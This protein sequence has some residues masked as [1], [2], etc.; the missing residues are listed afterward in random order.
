VYPSFDL[1]LN[2]E[3]TPNTYEVWPGEMPIGQ[4]LHFLFF[5]RNATGSGTNGFH[6]ILN[7]NNQQNWYGSFYT[8]N[9]LEDITGSGAGSG[10]PPF[11]AGQ[12][13]TWDI[14]FSGSATVDLIY[15]PC[16]IADVCA[17]GLGTQLVQ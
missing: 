16:G 8:P 14:K 3:C 12:I 6:F 17:S 11:I 1:T 7:G 5:S 10:G 2:G 15:R 9:A 13:V 4:H